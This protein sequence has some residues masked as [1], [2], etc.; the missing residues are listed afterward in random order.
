MSEFISGSW[1]S[2]IEFMTDNHQTVA[3]DLP[4]DW[5]SQPIFLVGAER[6]GT[7]VCRLMLDHH[8]LITWCNEFEYAVDR[9]KT[10]TDW[11]EIAAYQEWL[12]IHR[13]FQATGFTV[14]P[15]LS[16]PELVNSF[17]V[18]R[19]TTRNK[20]I[21]GATVH[22]H[23]DRLLW[24]W[25]E[26]KFLHIVR[27]PRD[28][29]PS[30]IGMGWSGNVWH[31]A[32]RWIEAEDLWDKLAAQLSPEQIFEFTYADL[33]QENQA[34]LTRICEF[35]GVE[36]DAKMLAY[37]EHTAYALPDPK[38]V[39]QWQKKLS[40]R[41]VQLVEARVGE[42]LTQRGFTPSGFAARPPNAWEKLTLNIQDWVM[43]VWFRISYFGLWLVL[44][45]FIARKLS[46]KQWHRRI[47]LQRN[48]LVQSR[49]KKSLT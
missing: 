29:A 43:R 47:V 19:K 12:G 5:I 46:L 2:T 9:V 17:L 8:P 36:Y 26:A 24:I 35:I 30:C 28:V 44:I 23:F 11:P 45:E 34:V 40:R 48:A 7:T 41:E 27:D 4:Q 21:V 6:S 3:A 16:Y 18:Q 14:D 32:Q 33:I 25:P 39:S 1:H 22:R 15:T 10:P 37:P 38:L 42:R 31:A 49:I 13:I 20:P